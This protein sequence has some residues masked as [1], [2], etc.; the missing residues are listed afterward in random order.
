VLETGRILTD[1]RRLLHGHSRPD[2]P[3][4]ARPDLPSPALVPPSALVPMSASPIDMSHIE[5]VTTR[6]IPASLRPALAQVVDRLV[7]GDFEGLRRD[8]IDPYPDS[9]PG[10]WIREYGRTPGSDDPAR[11]TLIS[12]PEEAWQYAEVVL[13]DAGP[14]RK[15]RVVVDLWTLEEGRSDLSMEA[16]VIDTPAGIQ[17]RVHDIHVM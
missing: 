8:G 3:Q 6:A 13:E 14:P 7:A 12:L 10:V 5:S 16:D 9:D 11:A 15:W 4:M 17:V 2:L 1:S